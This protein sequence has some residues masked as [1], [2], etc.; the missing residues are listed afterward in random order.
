M[1]IRRL[2]KNEK[3][4]MRNEKSRRFWW[5]RECIIMFWKEYWIWGDQALSSEIW[6]GQNELISSF[7]V[8]NS[9]FW[10]QISSFLN[11]K[12]IVSNTG[13]VAG[14]SGIR[15]FLMI[16]IEKSWCFIEKSWF[17]IEKW[18]EIFNYNQ[19][20]RAEAAAPSLRYSYDRPPVPTNGQQDWW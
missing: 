3:I 20:R 4:L 10:I 7:W 19:L 1:V 9:S 11:T 5:Q 16:S 12:F 15:C 13:T 14:L 2:C 17:S 18:Q 8:H 6:I